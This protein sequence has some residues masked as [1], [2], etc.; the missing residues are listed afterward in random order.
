MSKTKSGGAFQFFGGRMR[1]HAD[2]VQGGGVL[3]YVP[4]QRGM[5]SRRQCPRGGGACECLQAPPLSGNPVSA[6]E[7]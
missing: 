6:P 5:T 2:N 1:R 3:V 7:V 4:R